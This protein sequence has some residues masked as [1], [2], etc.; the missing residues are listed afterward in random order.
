MDLK[1]ASDEE[2]VLALQ[3][4]DLRQT[5]MARKGKA[6]FLVR[7]HCEPLGHWCCPAPFFGKQRIALN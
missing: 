1:A 2:L 4:K 5:P 3:Q 6:R 7:Q